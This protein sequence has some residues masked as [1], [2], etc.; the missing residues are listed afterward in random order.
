MRTPEEANF[1]VTHTFREHDCNPKSLDIQCHYE[2]LN[3]I[4]RTAHRHQYGNQSPQANE[5][6]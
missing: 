6:N 1:S 5:Q 4:Y 3:H 2:L